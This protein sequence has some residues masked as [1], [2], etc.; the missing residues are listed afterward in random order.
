MAHIR[1]L[2]SG[3][4]TAVAYTRCVYNEHSQFVLLMWQFCDQCIHF[5]LIVCKKYSA[6]ALC[7]CKSH[8]KVCAC[9]QVPKGLRLHYIRH[10][11]TLMYHE[12][13]NAGVSGGIC[14]VVTCMGCRCMIHNRHVMYRSHSQ[15]SH[16][17]TNSVL[18][19]SKLHA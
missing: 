7:P 14:M 12:H 3:I 1:M 19:E 5:S 10:I 15:F 6:G 9:C 16:L 8:V 2:S 4:T 17:S 18:Q 13:R 11:L